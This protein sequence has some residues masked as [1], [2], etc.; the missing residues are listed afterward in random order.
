MTLVLGWG[1]CNDINVYCS[2]DFQK[3]SRLD[4]THVTDYISVHL[5]LLNYC[6][7]NCMLDIVSYFRLT[8][9]LTASLVGTYYN[10]ITV[11]T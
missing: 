6:N 1:K 5:M 9:S 10:C 7:Y 11:G 3:S 2:A 4:C 8:L